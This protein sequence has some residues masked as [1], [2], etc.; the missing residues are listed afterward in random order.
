M[1]TVILTLTCCFLLNSAFTQPG[2]PKEAPVIKVP[3]FA[4]ADVKNFYQS[5]AD[6]LIKCIKAIREKNE[7]KVRTLF[8]NPGEE[9]VA[10][11]KILSKEV[12]KNAVEKKKYIEFAAQVYPY[13]K[14]VKISEYYKKMYG[15]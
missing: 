3:D 13:L 8:K 7:E 2:T 4:N 9:L 1:K 15:E 5:Y 11:E 12:V 6:H 14:E 10:R